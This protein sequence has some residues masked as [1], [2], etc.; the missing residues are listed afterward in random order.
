M[1]PVILA[2]I[3]ST[4]SSTSSTHPIHRHLTDVDSS[5]S[6]KSTDVSS[7]NSENPEIYS[8]VVPVDEQC[9]PKEAPQ[10][11][12]RAVTDGARTIDGLG[13]TSSADLLGDFR[14]LQLTLKENWPEYIS[15]YKEAKFENPSD[16]IQTLA[17][18]ISLIPE[19]TEPAIRD[20]L[21]KRVKE[22]ALNAKMTEQAVSEGYAKAA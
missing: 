19:N 22:T 7:F 1:R 15:S 14:S 12:S 16:E 4:L 13:A 2:L 20:Y 5:K 18:I 3:T 6:L 10:G 11:V 8:L 17:T 21:L 9:K